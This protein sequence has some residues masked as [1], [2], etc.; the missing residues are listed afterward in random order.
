MVNIFSIPC[1]KC[2]LCIMYKNVVNAACLQS[3]GYLINE[4]DNQLM[5][6]DIN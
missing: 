2:Y 3:S 1:S 6:I 5:P 4:I